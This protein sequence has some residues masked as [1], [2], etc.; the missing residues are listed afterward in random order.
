MY[1]AI[2]LGVAYNIIEIPSHLMKW[3][4]FIPLNLGNSGLDP[5]TNAVP[6]NG[7]YND[8]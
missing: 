5:T 7:N 6:Q 8:L 2:S 3:F 1:I 4:P